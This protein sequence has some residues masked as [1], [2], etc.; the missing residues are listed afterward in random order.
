MG[1]TYIMTQVFSTMMMHIFGSTE[2]SRLEVLL[3]SLYMAT[4][5]KYE[6][7]FMEWECCIISKTE[8]KEYTTFHELNY[9]F[10]ACE[11]GQH[12][13]SY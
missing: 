5:L 10:S 13:V 6:Y 12:V 1:Q 8:V 3:H 9:S 2:G 7:H 11:A 4:S